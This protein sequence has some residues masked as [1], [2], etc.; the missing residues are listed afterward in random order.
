MRHHDDGRCPR[1]RRVRI[2]VQ[3]HQVGLDL[4]SDLEQPPARPVD[5]RPRLVHPL[6]RV[7]RLAQA[8]DA[9]AQDLRPLVCAQRRA[10]GRERHLDVVRRE[11]VDEVER[12]RPDAADGVCRHENLHPVLP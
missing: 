1:E 10:R 11:R 6:E 9:G 3:V 8:G 5:V 12:V 4:G 7:A 2:T